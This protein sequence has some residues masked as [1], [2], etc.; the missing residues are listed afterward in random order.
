MTSIECSETIG[1][2]IS[3][4]LCARG[5]V[6]TLRLAVTSTFTKH[7]PKTPHTHPFLSHAT[8]SDR[9]SWL[10]DEAVGG[11]VVRCLW[12][13]ARSIQYDSRFY[14]PDWAMLVQDWDQLDVLGGAA[15]GKVSGAPRTHLSKPWRRNLTP[16]Y[17]VPSNWCKRSTP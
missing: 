8:T 16:V 1:G 2:V 5:I 12:H 4:G 14:S 3:P 6:L 7:M 15:P 11:D 9:P 10:P 17:G 13:I